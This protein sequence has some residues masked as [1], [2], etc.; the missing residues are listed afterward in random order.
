MNRKTFPVYRYDRD[1]NL[2]PE[3]TTVPWCRID[4]PE[5]RAQLPQPLRVHV[6]AGEVL[7]LPSLFYHEV[8]QRGDCN[9]ELCIAVNYW[10]DM[11][12]DQRVCWLHFAERLI[13]GE[14]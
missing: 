6:R 8:E 1:M 14:E 12:W 7:Y 2:H 10:Y 11:L 5:I 4:D 9:G 3:N 13:S